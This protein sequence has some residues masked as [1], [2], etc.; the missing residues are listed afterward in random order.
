MYETA[1]EIKSRKL[2][3]IADYQMIEVFRLLAEATDKR[4]LLHGRLRYLDKEL[5]NK[6]V[7]LIMIY[8]NINTITEL[9][10]RLDITNITIRRLIGK[11][12]K[13]TANRLSV[14][15]IIKAMNDLADRLEN[16][17]NK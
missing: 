3:E 14:D 15:K 7:H 6:C 8:D 9:C 16:E 1:D 10:E 5:L 17:L 4:C 12:D 2:E 13:Q 11:N